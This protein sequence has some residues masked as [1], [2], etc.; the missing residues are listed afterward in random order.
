MKKL[1]LA[2]KKPEE[3]EKLLKDSKKEL[4]PAIATS[5]PTLSVFFL[6]ERDKE[7]S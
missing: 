6:L 7:H 5:V 3:L 2:K 4:L 1:E